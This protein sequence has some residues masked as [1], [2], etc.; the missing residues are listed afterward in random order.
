MGTIGYWKVRINQ[1]FQNRYEWWI[2]SKRVWQI[3]V[4]CD[5]KRDWNNGKRYE[6]LIWSKIRT[7][8]FIG[9]DRNLYPRVEWI[10]TKLIDFWLNANVAPCIET[11]IRSIKFSKLSPICV[12]S[13]DLISDLITM[14]VIVTVY[15]TLVTRPSELGEFCWQSYLRTKTVEKCLS[16]FYI[17]LRSVIFVPLNIRQITS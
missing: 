9:F 6:Q 2:W 5:C 10:L 8:R 15:V 11:G 13:Y 14:V 7:D 3:M 1:K 12:Y 16:F 17:T 4:R